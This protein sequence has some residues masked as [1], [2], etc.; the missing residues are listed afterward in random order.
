MT[1]RG[2]LFDLDG[3][4][5]DTEPLFCAS[6]IRALKEQGI[7][8]SEE[9]FYSYWTRDG[10]NIQGFTKEKGV[11]VDVEKYRREHKKQYRN[12]IEETLTLMPGVPGKIKELGD[13]YLL[14]LVSSSGRQEVNRILELISAKKYFQAIVTSDDVANGKPAPDG[15]LLAAKSIGIKPE[16]CAVIEDAEKGILAAKQAGMKAIA[17]PN[18]YTANNDFSKADRRLDSLLS[19]TKELIDSL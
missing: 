12:I 2:I 15:F 19:L 18:K 16:E 11:T 8:L 17:I 9:E 10:K 13:G 6:V 1:I 5:V 14:G 7:E 4:L 3:L